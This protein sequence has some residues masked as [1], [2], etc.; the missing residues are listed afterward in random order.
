MSFITDKNGQV[1][2]LVLGNKS[3]VRTDRYSLQG[4]TLREEVLRQYEACKE[5]EAK[6]VRYQPGEENRDIKLGVVAPNTQ[7][8]HDTM[9]YIA[10]I[11]ILNNAE[12][13][14]YATGI[15]II[16]KENMFS[17]KTYVEKFKQ[18]PQSNGILVY[19][20]WDRL[21]I[22]RLHRHLFFERTLGPNYDRTNKFEYYYHVEQ[23]E[24]KKIE[25]FNAELKRTHY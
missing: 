19:S 16:H 25:K 17:Y 1:N 2:G 4:T 18:E 22:R 7:T 14:E 23:Q 3:Y 15:P 8:V 6:Y 24:I 12:Y 10:R 21:I 20:F 11:E 9:W 13:E 5:H